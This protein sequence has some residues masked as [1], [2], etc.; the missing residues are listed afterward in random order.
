MNAF[1]LTLEALCTDESDIGSLGPRNLRSP[2]GG[3]A[4]RMPRYWSTPTESLTP[5]YLAY[6]RSTT[7]KD[8]SLV[9][10]EVGRDETERS[11]KRKQNQNC[12]L[13]MARFCWYLDRNWKSLFSLFH[14]QIKKRIK[15]QAYI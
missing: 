9:S 13:M 14:E 8:S 12:E 10:S 15:I 3:A 6:P 7:G 5:S 11:C 4:Y 2:N 1:L